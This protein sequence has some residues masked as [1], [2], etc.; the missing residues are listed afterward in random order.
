MLDDQEEQ[1]DVEQKKG[2]RGS[3]VRDWLR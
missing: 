2:H 1:S 3:V